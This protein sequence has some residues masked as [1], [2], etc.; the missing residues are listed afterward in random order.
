MSTKLSPAMQ[1][2]IDFLPQFFDH[3]PY[4]AVVGLDIIESTARA[5]ER[6][7]IVTI[8]YQQLAAS[9]RPVIRPENFHP[10]AISRLGAL[11]ERT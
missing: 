3:Q 11:S 4:P 7:G 6:R 5:L 1:R 2:A 10:D 8:T 9:R